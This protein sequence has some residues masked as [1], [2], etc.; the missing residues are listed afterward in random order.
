M[1][2]RKSFTLIELLVV[3]AIIAIL[4]GMLLPALNK[5]REKARQVS[6]VSNL[7]QIGLFCVNYADDNL[8]HCPTYAVLPS[9][10]WWYERLY[11][12]SNKI[13]SRKFSGAGWSVTLPAN[14]ECPSMW[15]DLGKLIKP[16][17]EIYNPNGTPFHGG[18]G[19]N[20]WT[21]YNGS[22]PVCKL[23]KFK[24]PSTKFFVGDVY[25]GRV[26]VDDILYGENYWG[27][28]T[29]PWGAA[30]RHNNSMNILYIDGHVG[31]MAYK[32]KDFK[33]FYPNL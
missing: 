22:W 7:K 25:N 17:N 26:I 33:M 32:A 5:A 9:N 21:G 29:T 2:T 23:A 16:V 12:Y 18:Y 13:F 30:T 11:P 24:N 1:K 6:C 20:M 14:P 19:M 10:N 8:D 3:I 28:A 15:A 4:A 31:S 27:D